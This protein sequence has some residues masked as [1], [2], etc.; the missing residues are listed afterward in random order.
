MSDTLMRAALLASAIALAACSAPAEPPARAA[1]QVSAV[2]T[3]PPTA[4]APQAP[5][6]EARLSPFDAVR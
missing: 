6:S 3:L 2:R 5:Y 4:W 1:S